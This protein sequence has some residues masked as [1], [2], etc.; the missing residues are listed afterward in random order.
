LD[1]VVTVVSPGIVIAGSVTGK[2]PLAVS[3]RVDGRITVEGDV[4]IAQ[5]ARVVA[6]IAAD[7]VEVAGAVQG[8]VKATTAILLAPGAQV[9]GTVDAKR[10]E[11]DPQARIK[12][13][14]VMPITLPRG[15]KPPQTRSSSGW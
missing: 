4:R 1:N 7:T 6:S 11:I 14:L 12:G 5:K 2:G 8:D 10:V 9:E 15:V 3:G 13:R